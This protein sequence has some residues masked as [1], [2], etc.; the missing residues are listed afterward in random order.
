LSQQGLSPTTIEAISRWPKGANP[1]DV[2][3]AT[4]A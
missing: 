2:I 1:F 4:L 3:V